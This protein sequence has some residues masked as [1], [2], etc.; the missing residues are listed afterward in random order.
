MSE[1]QLFEERAAL[2]SALAEH[3]ATLLRNDIARRG[4]ASL[5]VSGGSTPKGMF[6]QLAAQSLPWE[7]VHITLVDERWVEVEDPD[8][9]E[10]L[11]RATLLQGPAAA[12]HFVSLNCTGED[13]ESALPEIETRL[14]SMPSPFTCVVL[15]MG[16][17]GHTASWF[18]R[19]SNLAALLDANSEYRVASCDPVTAAHQRITLT[20]PVVLQ[21]R[22]II[23]HI[24]GEEKRAVLD[25]AADNDYPVH[26]V[27]GLHDTTATI[28][29]AP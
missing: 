29:W 18:P 7:Q 12:A 19:A 1:Q 23:L 2:D 3:I 9:N 4:A 8:S 13:V 24:T 21:A 16:T 26:A 17:D 25:A 28:W 5:A 22:E 11:V 6:T 27:T 10:G 20:L 14:A 15:G